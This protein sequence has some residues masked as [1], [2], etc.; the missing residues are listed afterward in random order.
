VKEDIDGREGYDD[1]VDCECTWVGKEFYS[2]W[3]QLTLVV[4]RIGLTF[5]RPR[6]SLSNIAW[7]KAMCRLMTSLTE[8]IKMTVVAGE[9]SYKRCRRVEICSRKIS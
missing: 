6:V 1:F 3:N 5:G 7:G 9:V 4:S 2:L 8:G